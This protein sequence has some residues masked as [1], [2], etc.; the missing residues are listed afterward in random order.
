M[1]FFFYT[2]QIHNTL[3]GPSLSSGDSP[4]VKTYS[5][6][7]LRSNKDLRDICIE[8]HTHK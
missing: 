2:Q 8:V 7:A 3:Q 6:T 4:D 5:G 1:I